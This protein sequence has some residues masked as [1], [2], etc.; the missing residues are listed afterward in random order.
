MEKANI[1]L[2]S[3]TLSDK[4]WFKTGGL[5]NYFCAPATVDQFKEA[6]SYAQANNLPLFVLG[7]GANVLIADE[8]FD[9]L[10]ISPQLKKIEIINEKDDWYVQASA[11]VTM[12]ELIEFCLANQLT[13][14]EEFS[15]IPGTVG[16]SVF[17]NLHYYEF[18]LSDFLHKA[19]VINK[20]SGELTDVNPEWFSYGYNKSRLQENTDFL[21][22]ATFRVRRVTPIE[23]AY[24][25]GRSKEIIRHRLRRY[26]HGFTCGSF[27][28][29]F[30]TEEL[31]NKTHNKIIHVAYYLDKV[32][33]KGA[34]KIGDAQVSYQ[35]ANMLV[36][37]GAATSKNIIDLA[38]EMQ[39]LVI[40]EF[41]IIPQ[42]ECILV[43]FKNYPLL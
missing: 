15:G 43:G 42:P 2:R 38:K 28:R 32:G 26:P 41:G 6:I 25:Q 19:Q 39:K 12:P 40:N 18:F 11:G 23:T 29:N 21:V 36:N 33:V 7:S 24:A 14:L 22:Q 3:V 31:S 37:L 27:F 8:G 5:A 9:G 17:I 30:Y 35:H 20:A 10:I 16:G 4:N 34:L 1:I 13:N